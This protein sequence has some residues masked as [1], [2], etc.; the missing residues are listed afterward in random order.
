MVLRQRDQDTD[1]QRIDAGVERRA[2]GVEEGHV[3]IDVGMPKRGRQAQGR[4]EQGDGHRRGE[5]VLRPAAASTA[6]RIRGASR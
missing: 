4:A 3:S 1:H 2:K 6:A 5:L